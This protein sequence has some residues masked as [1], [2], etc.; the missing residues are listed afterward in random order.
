LH[1]VSRCVRDPRRKRWRRPPCCCAASRCRCSE[2]DLIAKPCA[3]TNRGA[4]RPFFFAQG[5]ARGPIPMSWLMR[6]PI[7]A[8]PPPRWSPNRTG[9]RDDPKR[10]PKHENPGRRIRRP[11][12]RAYAQAGGR[13]LAPFC[14]FST[15]LRAW[16]IRYL[17]VPRVP[18]IRT[19]MRARFSARRSSR[20][21]L[22]L[23]SILF[24]FGGIETQRTNRNRFQL[25]AR[26]D[27]GR[28]HGAAHRGAPITAGPLRRSR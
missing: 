11:V 23:P 25:E 16:S 22:G 17:P 14:R 9:S 24:L 19:R 18:R 20:F 12:S 4:G 6:G 7:A 8:A 5:D 21:P 28:G 2:G 26:P 27:W 1:G 3:N 13:K 10:S 15:G